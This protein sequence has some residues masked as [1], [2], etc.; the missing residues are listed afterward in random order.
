M[1]RLLF[2]LFLIPFLAVSAQAQQRC[3]KAFIGD[4]EVTEICVN[5]QVRF[6]DCSGTPNITAEFYDI[7][8]ANGQFDAPQV[9]D[10]LKKFIF[11]TPGTYIV[12]QLLTTVPP[13]QGSTVFPRTFIVRATPPPAFT[14]LQC[15]PDQV[16]VT[17]SHSC[18]DSLYLFL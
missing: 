5:T 1:L 8:D 10:P 11:S 12:G 4:R 15:G 6:E 9:N 16:K 13:T 2:S 17:I 18:Y 7:D 14:A 3:F